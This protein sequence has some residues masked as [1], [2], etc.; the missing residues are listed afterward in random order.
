MELKEFLNE[1]NSQL[2]GLLGLFGKKKITVSF[3]TLKHEKETDSESIYVKLD[4]KNEME[5][6]VFGSL[7]YEKELDD[8][9]FKKKL[10][11][12]ALNFKIY[13]AYNELKKEQKKVKVSE[14]IN[15]IQYRRR[16]PVTLN[17]L[18]KRIMTL[19]YYLGWGLE[20]DK[21]DLEGDFYVDVTTDYTVSLNQKF[22]LDTV[23]SICDCDTG[24]FFLNSRFELTIVIK[25]KRI[26]TKDDV[27]KQVEFCMKEKFAIG[28]IEWK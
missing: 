8:Q 26:F 24:Y 11:Q 15:K 10:S 2:N 25:D 18:L 1:Q 21:N 16:D 12:N 9:N 17:N 19:S 7:F 3:D 28:E 23:F 20:R 13:V 22:N 14:I 4:N 5:V 6:F 27:K